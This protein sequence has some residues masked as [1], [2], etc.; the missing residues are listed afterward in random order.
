VELGAVW[1]AIPDLIEPLPQVPGAND[2]WPRPLP[3]FLAEW[4]EGPM[5][6]A[7]RV[8]F[9]LLV[10]GLPDD[11]DAMA[12]ALVHYPTAAD[13][14]PKVLAQTG[15]VQRILATER[16]LPVVIWAGLL[17]AWPHLDAVAPDYRSL[18]R[19]MLLPSVAGDALS[20][21]MLWWV[22]LFGLS[23]IARYDPELWIKELDVNRSKLAVP[24][25][26][27]LETALEAIPD[28]IL[29]ALT[30]RRD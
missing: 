1:A 26:A 13:A 12:R 28:L 6:L 4:W 10:D 19:R 2:A 11:P 27:A 5:P 29:A 20:P 15:E 25:E 3:V 14:R 8:P 22:L 18:G 16:S 17:L 24:I 21:L 30:D 23:S 9:E 7:A